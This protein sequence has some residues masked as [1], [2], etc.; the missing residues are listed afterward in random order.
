ML[1]WLPDHST[2]FW[3]SAICAVIL[4]GIAKA[5]FGAGVG[6]LAT[7]LMALTMPV[8]E[9][10]ALLLPLLIISDI[11]AVANYRFHFDRRNIKLMLPG[12]F[13]GIMLGGVFFGYFMSKEQILKVGIGILSVAFVIFQ[14]ARSSI[15]GA[16][17]KRRAHG[18]EGVVMGAIAGFTSTLAHAGEPPVIVYLLPQKL[19]PTLF[20]GTTVIF[21]AFTNIVKLIPY[22]SLGLLKVGNLTTTALLSPLCYIGIKLGVCL[23]KYFSE[24]WFKRFV[25]GALFLTGVQLIAGKSLIALYFYLFP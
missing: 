22:G 2:G 9:A 19:S 11:F 1:P 17:E 8:A 18:A 12:A 7:P 23:N 21:F 14:L 24:T 15:L 13:V 5:G 25:Y 20:V 3:I 4:I 16:I 10:A 6:V